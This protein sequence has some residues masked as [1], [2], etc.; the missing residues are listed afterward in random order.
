MTKTISKEQVDRVIRRH[1]MASTGV[2]LLPV[3]AADIAGLIAVQ[4][5]MIKDIA[6]LYEVPFLKDAAKKVVST[7]IG[8]L[9]LTNAMPFLASMV[10]FI[11]VLGQ[12]VGVAAMPLACGASTYATGKVFVQHFESGG[13]FLT[14]DPEKV[15][16]HYAE[17][18]KE[19][20]TVVKNAK[21]NDD[22]K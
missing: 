16:A 14:F 17:M 20:K 8:G 22:E 3:P 2:G 18:M 4:V 11:P 9:L 15:K 13:T 21:E 12:A 1:T 5:N 7:L 6:E 19:G 10:K